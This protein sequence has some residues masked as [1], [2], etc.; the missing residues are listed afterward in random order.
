MHSHSRAVIGSVVGIGVLMIFILGF[1]LGGDALLP[2][3]RFS[4]LLGAFIGGTLALVSV[5]IPFR[6]EE[7]AEPWLGRERL[8]WTLIGCGFIGWS[9]GESFWRYYVAQGQ[10]PFPSLADLGYSSCDPLIFFGLFLRP[11]SKSGNRMFLLLDSLIAMGALLAIAWF[12]LLGPLAQTPAES[13]L[14]KILGLYYPT[15][16]VALLSCIVFLLIR[17]QDRLTQVRARRVSLLVFGLGLS[18]YASA[19]FL[20]NVLVN[21]GVS[22]DGTWIDLGWPLGIMTM[23][24][25]AYLRRFLP[26]DTSKRVSEEHVE[27][28]TRQGGFRPS[29]ALP[30]LLLAFLFFTLALNVLSSDKTQQSIRS[31]LLIATLLVIGLVVV[32][33]IITMLLNEQLLWKQTSMLEQLERVYQEIATRNAE[34]EA[35]VTHLKEVQTR[36]ANGDVRVRATITKGDLWPL[37]T[38]LNLMANRMMR[39]ESSQRYAQKVIEAVDDFSLA[40]ER[41]RKGGSPFALPLSCLDVPTIQRLA[42]VLGLRQASGAPQPSPHPAPPRP[43]SSSLASL[44][45]TPAPSS[46]SRPSS[47]STEA[48]W[49][50]RGH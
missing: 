34:L 11:F 14:G 25:A 15:A 41:S 40:L 50:P 46:P 44:P 31:V 23:G 32:R 26:R 21:M 43:A 9:I 18:V 16:D 6:R 12:L 7:N 33:Q 28:H 35:G 13:L 47:A 45:Q 8:G 29:Q 19:D 37:A 4:P 49:K 36:L 30:Y 38:G 5:N 24:V 20:F 39:S 1:H 42:L 22:V 27:R 2:I 48:Q 17:G 3:G 10:S